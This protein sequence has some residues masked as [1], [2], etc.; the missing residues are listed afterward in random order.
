MSSARRY[1]YNAAGCL[2]A[3][4]TCDSHYRTLLV[5]VARAWHALA[6]HDEAIEKLVVVWEAE[7]NAP[8][9]P[10]QPRRGALLGGHRRA[11]G[12]K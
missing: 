8:A 6:E 3:A 5:F 9:C 7:A 12:Q 2:Y 11:A 1:R 10:E 4:N